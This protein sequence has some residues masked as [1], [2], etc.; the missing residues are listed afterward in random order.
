MLDSI[1]LA[2]RGAARTAVTRMSARM[3]STRGGRAIVRMDVPDSESFQAMLKFRRDV[4]SAQPL[5]HP[6]LKISRDG[7]PYVSGTD[8]EVWKALGFAA[9]RGYFFQMDLIRRR[10]DGTQAELMGSSVL[11]NDLKQRSLG[12]SY[13]AERIVQ[14]L[15]RHEKAVLEG[16]TEGINSLLGCATPWEYAALGATPKPWAPSDSILLLQSLFMDLSDPTV[17]LLESQFSTSGAAL[18]T[19]CTV[20]VDGRHLADPTA[21]ERLAE[22]LA[23]Q[24]SVCSPGGATQTSPAIGSN[25]WAASRNDGRPI[26]ANDIHLPIGVPG[27]LSYV[28]LVRDGQ[29]AHGFSIPGVPGIVAGANRNLTWGVTRLCGRTSYTRPLAAD[30][31]LLVDEKHTVDGHEVLV[32]LTEDGPILGDGSVLRW[33]AISP[34][35]ANLG[36]LGLLDAATVQEGVRV[37]KNSG[38]PPLSILFADSNGDIGWSVSGRLVQGPS[39]RH[40]GQLVQPDDVPEIINPTS[41]RL[42]SANQELGVPTAEGESVTVNAYPSERALRISQLLD[43]GDICVRSFAKWQTDKDASIYRP[44]M[45]LFQAHAPS[46]SVGKQILDSWDGTAG[47]KSRG[48]HF[49]VLLH[50]LLRQELLG[51][52]VAGE[53]QPQFDIAGLSGLDTELLNLVRSRDERILPD[54]YLDWDGLFSW[55]IATASKYFETRLGNNWG[56]KEWGS[57]NVTR[58]SHP[59]AQ[60][61]RALGRVLDQVPT[62][63]PGCGHS[64]LVSAPKFGA[65]SRMVADPSTGELY[66]AWPG[67]QSS[68]PLDAGHRAGFAFWAAGRLRRHRLPQGRRCLMP[69]DNGKAI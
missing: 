3:A 9:A 8:E 16:Y 18:P 52:T 23:H 24:D 35:S 11:E 69:N 66:L 31:V 14:G 6:K 57:L 51:S 27:T 30:E 17:H 4:K 1:A 13:Y 12:L 21:A 50:A 19:G 55:C 41:G 34:Q 54:G 64:V 37:A 59:L 38:T 67:G 26:L 39:A 20:T 29:S 32:R 49:I 5:L 43:S 22:Y 53:N 48:F 25:S 7:T 33:S 40:P 65:A 42:I 47:R 44:W 36:I 46:G 45:E 15:S 63:Q 58:F 68:N 2:S 28:R 62:P 56:S 60:G 61:R 10:M